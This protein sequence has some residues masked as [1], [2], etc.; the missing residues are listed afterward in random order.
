MKRKH[1]KPLFIFVNGHPII[2]LDQF[3]GKYPLVHFSSSRVEN[4][5][6]G[7]M[8]ICVYMEANPLY[9]DYFHEFN[10]KVY[11]NAGE[12]LVDSKYDKY[13]REKINQVA[14][15][16]SNTILKKYRK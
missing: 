7:G 2:Q 4:D 11:V 15:A 9:P 3:V 1:T 5:P 10:S 13:A 8:V 6:I 14:S 16:L 12:W